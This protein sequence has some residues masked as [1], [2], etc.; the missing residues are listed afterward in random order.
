MK[1]FRLFHQKLLAATFLLLFVKTVTCAVVSS[2]DNE[3]FF[4]TGN[5]ILENNYEM[6][7]YQPRHVHISYGSESIAKL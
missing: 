4:E 3:E 7:R 2:Q 5:S 1:L 6:V